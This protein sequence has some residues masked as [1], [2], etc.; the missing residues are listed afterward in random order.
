MEQYSKFLLFG[1]SDLLYIAGNNL[2]VRKDNIKNDFYA[3]SASISKITFKG[4][5]VIQYDFTWINNA[6]TLWEA[7]TDSYSRV[8]A[9]R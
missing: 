5:T 9:K 3:M 6:L 8:L 1:A 7:F 2:N 4:T